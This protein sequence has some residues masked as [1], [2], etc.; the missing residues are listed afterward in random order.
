MSDFTTFCT[1]SYL[2]SFKH[3]VKNVLTLCSKY[4]VNILGKSLFLGWVTETRK[5]V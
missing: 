2:Q 1:Y 4:L 5:L 3:Y